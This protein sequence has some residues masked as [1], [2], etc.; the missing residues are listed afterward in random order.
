MNLDYNESFTFWN[1]YKKKIKK[2][3]LPGRYPLSL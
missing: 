1:K 3:I 2:K